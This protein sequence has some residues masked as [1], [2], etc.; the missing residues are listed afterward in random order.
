MTIQLF[1]SKFFRISV[2][3]PLL[4]LGLLWSNTALASSP[5]VVTADLPQSLGGDTPYFYNTVT[6]KDGGVLSVIP[7][8]TPGGTGRLHIK[9]NKIVIEAAGILDASGA[10]YRGLTGKAGSGPGGGGFAANYSGGG[11]A[12]FGDGGAGTNPMCATGIFGIGG[13]KYGMIA[14]PFELGSAGGAGGKSPGPIG[15]SGGGSVILEAAEIQVFGTINVS[16][17]PGLSIN[18]VGS[19]AG[20]GG[21]IRL[22][23]SLFTWGPKARLLANG[24]IGG[25]AAAESGGSGSGGLIWLH[26]GPEPPVEVEL[27]VA[28][29]ASAEACMS[30]AGAG[31]DGS[32]V[33]DS[34]P[35]ACADL[36]GDGFSATICGKDDCDDADPAIHP[37]AKDLCD[38]VD[39]DCN[40]KIDDAT[41]ACAAG[42]VC[43]S[44]M[45]ES[46]MMPDA[47]P[48]GDGGTPAAPDV[49][50]YRGGCS[51]PSAPS[52]AAPL[53][54]LGFAIA[55]GARV[56][57][58]S[59]R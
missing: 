24:G 33:K 20:A 56:A 11:G 39:N 51:V 23:A 40:S 16:G 52:G 15:G 41:D 53:A 31:A 54:A 18:G 34:A 10:G 58:R 27:N 14:P 5:L 4:A 25:K 17:D 44:G 19:G 29:G 8:G 26:G 36:D 35:F 43:M 30:G 48:E 21:E 1:R 6:I 9:A 38:N 13:V 55:L 47:G 50:E 22:Q 2:A 59:R 12:Y 46:V 37:M 3:T 57:R 49:L 28:G 7:V 42:L 45:C 32:V